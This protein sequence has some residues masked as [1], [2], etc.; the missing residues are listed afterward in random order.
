MDPFAVDFRV[1]KRIPFLNDPNA[2]RICAGE[3]TRPGVQ[4]LGVYSI[5]IQFP[6]AINSLSVSSTAILRYPKGL[7][8]ALG[9]IYL[10]STE[11]S[12][13]STANRVVFHLG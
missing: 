5:S 1:P 11:S 2:T 6:F 7:R 9:E 10:E 13:C 3:T 8:N 12:Y 4:L